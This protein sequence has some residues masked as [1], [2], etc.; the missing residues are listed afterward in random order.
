MVLQEG[1][2]MKHAKG[3]QRL[4]EGTDG[5]PP[6]L[7]YPALGRKESCDKVHP[8]GN[9]VSVRCRCALT[10]GGSS[11]RGDDSSA[12]QRGDE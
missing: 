8:S 6:Y 4:K 7:I 2:Q 10:G 12:G 11:G 3:N 5:L 9:G 1:T